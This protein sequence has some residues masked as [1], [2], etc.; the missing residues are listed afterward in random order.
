MTTQLADHPRYGNDWLAPFDLAVRNE[1]RNGLRILDIGSG[2]RPYLP[3]GSR[4]NG[5]QYVGLDISPNELSAAPLDSYDSV[6]VSDVTRAVPS[7]VGEFDLAVSW[8]VFEHVTSMRLALH[9][10]RSY[11]RPG[12]L[13][14]A[15]FSGA[16]SMFGIA[17]R[18]IPDRL[19]AF[20]VESLLHLD[21][22]TVFPARYDA[23]RYDSLVPLLRFWSSWQITP[24]Y[25]AAGYLR[26]LKPAQRIY[27]VLE[28][29]MEKGHHA[30]LATHY[31]VVAR[32]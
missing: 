32:R 18:L 15:Q 21:P 30:N 9:N 3:V 14:V 2:R 5:T 10:A 13:L 29:L 11:L 17:N 23:C 25:R 1:L 7:L 26:F 27:L 19:S 12:G 28:D 6:V 16:W 24:R 8:Q 22:S 4:P 31:L 20:A